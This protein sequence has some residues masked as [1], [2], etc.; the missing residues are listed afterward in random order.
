MAR[1]KINKSAF[2]D[3]LSG[4]THFPIVASQIIII[5]IFNIQNQLRCVTGIIIKYRS[6]IDSVTFGNTAFGHMMAGLAAVLRYN[7]IV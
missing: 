1:Q 3:H 4:L 5:I 2:S 6:L 7:G